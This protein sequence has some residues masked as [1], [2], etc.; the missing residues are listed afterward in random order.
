[1]EE[2]RSRPF[3]R[4]P[5]PGGVRDDGG[6][7]FVLR[8]AAATLVNDSR[9]GGRGSCRNRGHFTDIPHDSAS[10][11]V[12]VLTSPQHHPS[13]DWT[14]ASGGDRMCHPLTVG[15][16]WLSKRLRD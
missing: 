1:M 6:C 8:Y 2:T 3:L 11:Q 15:E 16:E 12:H 13:L 7:Q 14:L 5:E 10:G 4:I 9:R